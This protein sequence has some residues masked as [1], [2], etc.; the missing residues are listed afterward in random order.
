MRKKLATVLLV[1][2]GFA[3]FAAGSL[4]AP[5]NA[6]AACKLICCPDGHCITCCHSPCPTLYCGP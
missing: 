2:A 6:E 1:L 4:L 5:D 3:G